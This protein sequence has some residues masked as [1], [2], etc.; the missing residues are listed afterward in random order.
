MAF[1]RSGY[2]FIRI[3]DIKARFAALPAA[4]DNAVVAVPSGAQPWLFMFPADRSEGP[5]GEFMFTARGEIDW[6]TGTITRY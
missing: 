4:L 6:S 5:R 3:S 2:A 1:E